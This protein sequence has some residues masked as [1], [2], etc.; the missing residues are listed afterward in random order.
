MARVID[1]M[2]RNVTDL[3]PGVS[4]EGGDGSLYQDPNVAP[5]ADGV[6]RG[7]NRDIPNRGSRSG[8]IWG[9][10]YKANLEQGYNALGS[11]HLPSDAPEDRWPHGDRDFRFSA[12]THTA[13]DRYG[14]DRGIKSYDRSD[15]MDER[16]IRSNDF[17]QEMTTGPKGPLTN[18]PAPGPRGAT[19]A[20]GSPAEEAAE[21]PAEEAKEE[22]QGKGDRY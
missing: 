6:V 1:Q 9:D 12:A 4:N 18:G 10:D 13:D 11:A 15:G 5:P 8:V 3:P 21:S 22:K 14:E 7:D 19:M 16:A 2:S 20:E 17:N